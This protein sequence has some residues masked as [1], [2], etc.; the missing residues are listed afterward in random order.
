MARKFEVIPDGQVNLF[1]L[2]G[3]APAAEIADAP[4]PVELATIAGP[5]L[6]K[7]WS[8]DDIRFL[9]DVLS[10]GPILVADTNLGIPTINSDFGA[11]VVHCGFGLM[12]ADGLGYKLTFDAGGAMQRTP[13]GKGWTRLTVEGKYNYDAKSVR[14]K[15]EAYLPLADE[16]EAALVSPVEPED[17]QKAYLA[18]L[19]EE[20]KRNQ[21]LPQFIVVMDD[22]DKLPFTTIDESLIKVYCVGR[23]VELVTGEIVT[24]TG[25]FQSTGGKYIETS[26]PGE[27]MV[28]SDVQRESQPGDARF[29]HRSFLK[30]V[31]LDE[32]Q[33]NEL[34]KEVPQ[35][36]DMAKPWPAEPRLAD[37]PV[38]TVEA[39]A[40]EVKALYVELGGDKSNESL[41]FQLSAKLA[42]LR[43]IEEDLM[44]L[45]DS[46]RDTGVQRPDLVDKTAAINLALGDDFWTFVQY[47]KPFL[48]SLKKKSA[49]EQAAEFT[50]ALGYFTGTEK[51][52]RYP[53]LCPHIVLLTD[54]ALYVAEKGG[55]DGNTAYWLI[56]AIAS[57]QGEA[58][59]KRHEFQ[60][61]KLEVHPPDEP[62]P[63][64]NTVM[65]VMQSKASPSPEKPF[66]SH[67]HASLICTNGN[68]KELVRQEI[69]MT[70]FLPVGEVT[71]YAS[72]EQHPDVSKQKKVMILLLP[73]E[74]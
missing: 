28:P 21:S 72:V 8:V 30:G 57:Y 33:V 37:T 3:D 23:D 12:K 45:M 19:L 14:E 52:T 63:A 42:E 6:P 60:V 54:G 41:A 62:G 61:W 29:I 70:D 73:S 49:K 64:Q 55:E 35:L 22:I 43:N 1:D 24:I 15:L 38:G 65:A 7:G 11:E 4:A 48:E 34:T 25:F 16:P 32:R 18:E 69:E 39:L 56:D 47:V 9:L 2:F 46:E 40:K 58:V 67:R 66:N 59:L 20:R 71:I 13:S 74:Y 31:L 68:E 53:A 51:W 10:D 44:S 17:S 50:R 36:R 26:Q 27:N 5:M